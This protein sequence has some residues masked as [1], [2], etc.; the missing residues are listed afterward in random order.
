MQEATD[1]VRA[2]ACVAA[3]R[4]WDAVL[5]AEGEQQA[6]Q[7]PVSKIHRVTRVI[8]VNQSVVVM[9]FLQLLHRL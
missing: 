4:L 9:F 2:L 1:P 8:S 6:R 3:E 7:C 5:N